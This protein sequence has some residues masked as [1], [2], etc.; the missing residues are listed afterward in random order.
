M[1]GQ[2]ETLLR[3]GLGRVG[4]AEVVEP[5]MPTSADEVK[6]LSWDDLNLVFALTHVMEIRAVVDKGEDAVR[7]AVESWMPKARTALA[8]VLADV[9]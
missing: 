3:E 9:G 5:R 4:E 2:I 8:R 6:D 7:S 1:R